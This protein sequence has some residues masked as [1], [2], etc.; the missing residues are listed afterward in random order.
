MLQGNSPTKNFP[1]SK[2]NLGSI[3]GKNQKQY[4]SAPLIIHLLKVNECFRDQIN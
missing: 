2:N 1:I 4:L 3:N